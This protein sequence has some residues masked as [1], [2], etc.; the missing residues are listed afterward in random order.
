MGAEEACVT[1]C[2]CEHPCGGCSWVELRG[3][4]PEE[5]LLEAKGACDTSKLR[6][7]VKLGGSGIDQ[8]GCGLLVHLCT[9]LSDP[10]AQAY[11]HDEDTHNCH[12][13][14]NFSRPLPLPCTD[15]RRHTSHHSL[16]GQL[17]SH[18]Q[19]FWDEEVGNQPLEN[20]S[21][22]GQLYLLPGPGP[23]IPGSPEK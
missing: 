4:A 15:G 21:F 2:H 8:R 3:A 13:H 22:S 5:G 9:P 11:V 23:K 1:V 18:T 17:Q 14:S 19:D 6:P 10:R 16:S 12:T 7:L 20:P